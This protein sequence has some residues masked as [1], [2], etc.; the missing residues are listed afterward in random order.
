M[1]KFCILH[2]AFF[3]SFLLCATGGFSAS[4]ALVGKPPVPHETGPATFTPLMRVCA[5]NGTNT[6]PSA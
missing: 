4:A 5:E 6:A 3:I 1:R 2:S